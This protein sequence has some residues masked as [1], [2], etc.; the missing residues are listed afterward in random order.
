MLD[1]NLAPGAAMTAVHEQACAILP[2]R[3]LAYYDSGS[4]DGLSVAEAPSSWD[5]VRLRPRVLRDVSESSASTTVL[6]TPLRSPL[7][8][9]PS[10]SHRL[11]HPDGEVATA[12]GTARAGS[13][14]V[15]STRSSA[16]MESV[17][18]VAGPWWMQV[19]VL[20]DRGLSDEIAQQAAAHGAH[21]L[22]LT[23]DTPR[24][25]RKPTGPIPA[26]PSERLL[27]SLE[28]RD[29]RDGLRQAD[30]VTVAD[31]ARLREASGLPVVV[32]GVLRADD[33][34]ACAD[35]GA[36]GVVVSNHGGRQLDGAIPTAWAL[37]EVATALAGTDTEVYVDGG[38]R[39]GRHVL[40]ALALGARAV[41]IGRPVLWALAIAG[42]DGVAA[43]LENLA[44]DTAEAL[45][46]AGC[47]SVSDSADDLVWRPPPLGRSV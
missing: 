36:A 5:A 11:A 44:D 46:L 20:R 8:V 1:P 28:G 39:T 30:T 32:K 6:G 13:L 14:L 41:L 21:A 47:R 37:P 19:Y 35:A 4:G 12:A 18:A 16:R 22:V 38:I 24:L 2:D 34:L 45:V 42:A 43:L 7:L 26:L 29:V 25:G 23:G 15:L 17:A 3:V 40:T 31:I 9:A 10:A 27:P 33:A